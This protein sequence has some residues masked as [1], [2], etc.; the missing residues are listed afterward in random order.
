MHASTEGLQ[1]YQVS[2]LTKHMNDK[3]TKSYWVSGTSLFKWNTVLTLV[4]TF[5]V[6]FHGTVRNGTEDNVRHGRFCIGRTLL[7]A[8]YK[9]RPP[10]RYRYLYYVCSRLEVPNVEGATTGSHWRQIRVCRK[11][12]FPI[13]SILGGDSDARWHLPHQRIPRAPNVPASNG[14]DFPL[15]SVCYYFADTVH[16]VY[17]LRTK[18]LAMSLG[19]MQRGPK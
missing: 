9:D 14:T 10:S 11:I 5:L 2:T 6:C 17:H 3:L 16:V 7:C 1:Q 8:T 18:S 19:Q 12:L 13:D 4:L 15:V